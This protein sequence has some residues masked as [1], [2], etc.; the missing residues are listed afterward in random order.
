MT[1]SGIEVTDISSTMH[2]AVRDAA[3]QYAAEDKA[4]ARITLENA[5]KRNPE[6]K[7]LWLL[8][9]DLNRLE[10]RW[11]D[12]EQAAA[13]YRK[14]FGQEPPQ[15]R[16]RR[17]FEAKLPEMLRAGGAA[18]WTLGGPI[19][20]TVVTTIAKIQE[21]S[22]HHVVLHIDVSRV[23]SADATGCALLR[24]ALTQLLEKGNGLVLTGTDNLHRVLSKSHYADASAR[25]SWQLTLLVK[26]IMN[27]RMGF[28]RTALEFALFSS[29]AAPD[30]EPVMM[31]KPDSP[32]AQERRGEP[33]YVAREHVA[34]QG[35]IDTGNNSQFEALRQFAEANQYVNIDLSGV[36][37]LAFEPA[38]KLAE[39]IHDA[40]SADKL[41][42][43]IR[44]NQLVLVLLE[45]LNLGS[46]ATIVAPSV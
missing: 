42:R 17:E 6:E 21:A 16:A 22:T 30:W 35:I 20:G 19:D 11:P 28:E 8:L 40:V 2:P 29:T 15:D 41:V 27:D 14:N 32:D 37:R 24:D 23:T 7:R 26:R 18:C 13:E 9:L 39:I 46:A 36:E 10:S 3:M 5:V 34:L 1:T 12:Y 38:T 33:R 44:P 45:L 4:T 43:L 31:P 25:A